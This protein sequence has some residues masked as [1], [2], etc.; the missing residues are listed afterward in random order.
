MNRVPYFRF[1]D[2]EHG[3]DA[4]K[5]AEMGYEVP[6]IVTF[7]QVTPHGHKGDPMEFFAEEWIERKGREAR[8]GRY[9]HSWVS[10]FKEGLAAYRA[11]KEL[12]RAGTP[13]LTWE[14]ILKSR[15]EQLAA[16]YPTLED[17]AAVPD[18]A[19]GEIGMDGRVLRDMAVA[20]L[21][22]KRD[23]SPLVKE[24]AD[25]REDKRRLEEVVERLETRLEALEKRRGRPPNPVEEAA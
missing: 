3:V 18:S 12:P 14:R 4:E 16:R 25:L 8:E 6:K 11:G 7:I 20:E 13:L 15:R 10:E 17:L 2:R 23:L 19:I 21:Q 22:A 9:E 5:T 1:V 24:V